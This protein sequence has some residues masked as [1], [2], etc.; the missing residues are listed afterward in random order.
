MATNL[1]AF[2]NGKL[3]ADFHPNLRGAAGV[4]APDAPWYSIFG[5]TLASKS[6]PKKVTDVFAGKKVVALY[7]SAGW[8]GPC[9]VFKPFLN[10]LYDR[11]NK[12]NPGEFEMIFM[13]SCTDLAMFDA[14]VATMDFPSVRWEIA[15]EGKQARAIGFVRKAKREA[16]QEQGVLGAKYGIA[17][18]PTVVVVDGETGKAIVPAAHENV[19]GGGYRLLT[20]DGANTPAEKLWNSLAEGSSARL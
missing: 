9:Q 15:Q 20:I 12:S 11:A 5:E 2:T 13:S 17:S 19:E 18:V 8:C 4:D 14:S 3:D 7:F 10:D 1:R 6:G 16:G